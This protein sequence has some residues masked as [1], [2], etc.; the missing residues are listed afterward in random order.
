MQ[1]IPKYIKLKSLHNPTSEIKT[2]NVKDD[3]QRWF[4]AYINEFKKFFYKNEVI[5]SIFSL[6]L[7]YY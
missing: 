2:I 4:Y 6:C 7:I 5:L 3:L 1:P